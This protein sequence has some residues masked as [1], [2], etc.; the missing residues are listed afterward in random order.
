[1]KNKKFLIKSG[2]IIAFIFLAFFCAEIAS[3]YLQRRYFIDTNVYLQQAMPELHRVS[4]VPGLGYE[5][6]PGIKTDDGLFFINS[7]GLR[8]GEYKTP[9]PEGVYRIIILGDS[10][11]FGT[12]YPSEQT[13]PK[14]LEKLLNQKPL[15]A[16][17]PEVLNAG[18]C[19][20]NALQKFI[21]LRS[22]LL[23]YEPDLVIFQ[24][25]NDDY[26]RNAVIM[27][28][29]SSGY[30]GHACISI[31]EYF[32]LN[33]PQLGCLPKGLNRFL[34]KNS[35]LYR[36][37]NVLLY[38]RLSKLYPEKYLPDVYKFAGFREL[39]ASI[40]SNKKIFRDFHRLSKTNGFEFVI[41]LFP[42]LKNEDDLDPWIKTECPKLYNFK[43]I[44]LFNLFKQKG[45]DLNSLRV[46]QQGLCHLNKAGHLITAQ[47]IYEWLSE[48][49]DKFPVKKTGQIR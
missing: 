21:F 4:Q 12:E 10:V 1:M 28:N 25:L 30:R 40:E 47:I 20:Y 36:Q 32:S 46:T 18:V 19:A 43:T 24:F 48:N 8:D 13:Y 9:K 15:T 31:G 38:D 49:L 3:H 42:A 37:I 35:A 29:A 14:V 27:P 16:L 7:K 11:T 6:V 2:I 22:K 44:N 5:L 39:S 26:Y 41:L 17:K 23:D 45:I 33:F 34:L